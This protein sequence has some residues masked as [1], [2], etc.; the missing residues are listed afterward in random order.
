ML[1]CFLFIFEVLPCCLCFEP[2]HIFVINQFK[3]LKTAK[4]LSIWSIWLLFHA[5][6][7]WSAL[8]FR[9]NVLVEYEN[10][11]P[12]LPAK[13]VHAQR[14]NNSTDTI[15]YFLQKVFVFIEI[16]FSSHATLVDEIS[17]VC[18]DFFRFLRCILAAI[19]PLIKYLCQCIC[20]K[21]AA[22]GKRNM[23]KRKILHWSSS[24][25]K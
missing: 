23:K 25:S 14:D 24:S 21:W 20:A 4:T 3:R 7:F 17:L 18:L 11:L 22:W 5:V 8:K 16:G 9:A 6:V 10:A 15:L 13:Y 1:K 19:N 12:F 2:V